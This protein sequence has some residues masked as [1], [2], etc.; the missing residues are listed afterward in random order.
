M[1]VWNAEDGR[2]LARWFADVGT[3][4]TAC[5]VFQTDPKLIVYVDN[6]GGVNMLRFLGI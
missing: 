6:V 2:E 4:V 5:S 1:R 3:P